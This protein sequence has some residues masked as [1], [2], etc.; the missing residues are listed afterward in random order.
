MNCH[1]NI[2]KSK[3]WNDNKI[4]QNN[5]YDFNSGMNDCQCSLSRLCMR[6]EPSHCGRTFLYYKKENIQSIVTSRIF[7]V[8]FC[9]L[10]LCG[11]VDLWYLK[12]SYEGATFTHK[13]PKLS[14]DFIIYFKSLCHLGKTV[15]QLTVAMCPSLPASLIEEFQWLT[16]KANIIKWTKKHIHTQ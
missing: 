2:G 8:G 10:F 12:L 11:Y 7:T 4:K 16:R 13:R 5:P 15:P 1:V 14:F 9:Q 3:K 6:S